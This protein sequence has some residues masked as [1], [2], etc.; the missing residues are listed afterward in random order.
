MPRGRR[1]VWLTASISALVTVAVVGGTSPSLSALRA[2]GFPDTGG[3]LFA[4]N[5]AGDA[6][7]KWGSVDCAQ[8]T[9]VRTAVGGAAAHGPGEAERRTTGFRHL[10]VVDGD[11]FY[12]E[13]CE[14]GLNDHRSSP[15]ALY[16]EGERRL[17]FISIRL[18]KHFPLGRTDWQTVMQMKQTQP[19]AAGGGAPMIELQA[20]HGRWLLV[21]DWEPV[22]AGRAHKGVWTRFAFDVR[23][24]QNPDLGTIRVYAD[25]NGDGDALDNR[26]RSRIIHR[27][28]LRRESSGGS[29]T[30]GIAPGESI[31]SHLRVGI[32]HD[33]A[34]SCP[35]SRC[36][37]GIDDVDVYQLP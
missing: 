31:P 28:T 34:Y 1:A 18:P 29:P 20:R 6:I 17:T 15:V 16:H 36:S 9:R 19:A 14:L 13:R 37:I 32:Y 23:Y 8:P 33:P 24:S 12:G 10:K 2:N 5:G 4:D 30:D 26:E 21:D 11:N 25:R 22:W 27:A 35:G 3:R 7:A